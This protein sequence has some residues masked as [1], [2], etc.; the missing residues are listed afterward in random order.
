M[1][2]LKFEPGLLEK[3]YCKI[4]IAAPESNL[5]L[6]PLLEDSNDDPQL[7]ITFTGEISVF[8]FLFVKYNSAEKKKPFKTI[9]A[10]KIH[11]LF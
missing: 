6:Q 9:Y 4:M 2:E 3:H 5:N 10:K 1:H 11:K 8:L 7:S